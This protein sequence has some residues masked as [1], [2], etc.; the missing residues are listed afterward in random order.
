MSAIQDDRRLFRLGQEFNEAV[1]DLLQAQENQKRDPLAPQ[2]VPIGQLEAAR[3]KARA[4]YRAAR[5]L[6]LEGGA[7]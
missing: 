1:Y 2:P 3:D 7:G 5:G 6:R 4:A